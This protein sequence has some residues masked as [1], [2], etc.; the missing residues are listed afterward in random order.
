ME[1]LIVTPPN[2][3]Q[4]CVNKILIMASLLHEFLSDRGDKGLIVSFGMHATV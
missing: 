3:A 2:I 4:V 1:Y